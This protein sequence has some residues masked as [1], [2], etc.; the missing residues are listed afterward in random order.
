MKITDIRCLS[1][2]SLNSFPVS[3]FTDFTPTLST[4]STAAPTGLTPKSPKY[5][6]DNTLKITCPKSIPIPE[7]KNPYL[8][9]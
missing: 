2:L 3:G 7:A 9:P 8:Y 6:G 1:S 5:F 4:V